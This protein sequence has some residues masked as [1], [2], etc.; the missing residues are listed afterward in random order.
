MKKTLLA[1]SALTVAVA[2]PALAAQDLS[3]Y[4]N[5]PYASPYNQQVSANNYGMNPYANQQQYGYGNPAAGQQAQQQYAPQQ[6]AYNNPYGAPANN[7]YNNYQPASGSS[8]NS[9]WPY[10]YLGLNAGAAIRQNDNW[11]NSSGSGHLDNNVGGEGSVT[12][13]YQ[14]SAFRYE[15][16]LGFADQNISQGSSSGNT[17]TTKLMGN[18]IYDFDMNGFSPFL[19]AGLGGVKV[20]LTPTNPA[21][22]DGNGVRPAYQLIGGVSVKNVFPETD[23][24]LAYKYLDALGNLKADNS[25]FDYSSHTLEAGA[26]FRF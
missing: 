14:P 25:K 21:A 13:G 5:Q 17:K 19:G 15:A 9:R 24:S 1:L 6:Q 20:A 18:A 12:L 26:R 2:S 23:L 10:W 16:E 11:K 22:V 7:Q 8:N 3:A 4:G